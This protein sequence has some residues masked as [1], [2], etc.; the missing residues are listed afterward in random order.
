MP[1][2]CRIA[3]FKS[4]SVCVSIMLAL[5]Y[6]LTDCRMWSEIKQW[7]ASSINVDIQGKGGIRIRWYIH[8]MIIAHLERQASFLST[9][10]VSIIAKV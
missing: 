1:T 10:T 4:E 8:L 3:K 6:R 7:F 9:K 2:E 5:L